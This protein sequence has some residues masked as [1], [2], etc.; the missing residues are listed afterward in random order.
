[1]CGQKHLRSAVSGK[2]REWTYPA[3]T[4]LRIVPGPQRKTEA[5]PARRIEATVPIE[6][7]AAGMTVV[8]RDER[9]GVTTLR[10][11]RQA[12]QR[13]AEHL[14]TVDLADPRA[15]QVVESITATPEHPFYVQGQGFQPLGSLGIS[16]ST[17]TRAG[18]QVPAGL[19][20]PM[21]RYPEL[22]AAGASRRG[23]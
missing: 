21:C 16:V 9:S 17:V 8:S 12:F 22:G 11:V 4:E 5:S 15:G 10:R 13:A 7:V 3:G 1:L 6:H 14:V 2:E 23:R 20:P 19:H 18:R